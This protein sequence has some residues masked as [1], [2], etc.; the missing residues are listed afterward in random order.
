MVKA[1]FTASVVKMPHYINVNFG[2]VPLFFTN[3]GSKWFFLV[4]DL[5]SEIA[6]N[7]Q[8][9]IPIYTTIQTVTLILTVIR[10]TVKKVWNIRI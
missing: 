9:F 8:Y 10:N 4:I 1:L 3:V 2:F 5:V 6:F 7:L